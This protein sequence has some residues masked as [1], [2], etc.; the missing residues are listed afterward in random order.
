M[1]SILFLVLNIVFTLAT[2]YL[3]YAYLGAGYF[4]AALMAATITVTVAHR[5]MARLRY[6]TFVGNN[7]ATGR[8]L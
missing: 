4:L 5:E 1:L 2:Q 7:P 3:G 8:A 6:P